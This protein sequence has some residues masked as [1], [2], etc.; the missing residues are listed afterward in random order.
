MNERIASAIRER[1]KIKV[2]YNGG[3]RIL[4]PYCYGIST[5]DKEALRAYQK[6]GYSKKG[7]NVDW[8]FIDITKIKDIE[9]LEEIF[10]PDRLEYRKEDKM[11][12]IIYEQI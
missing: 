7:K 8:K 12:K 10:Y 4:E 1:K 2:N 9:I 3:W 11:M 6:E 5:D